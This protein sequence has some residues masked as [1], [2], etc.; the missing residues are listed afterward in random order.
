[1]AG[2]PL[3]V[4]RAL[5]HHYRIDETHS[6]AYTAWKRMGSPQKPTPEQYAALEAAGQ[7]ELLDSPQWVP[8]A[9][10]VTALDFVLPRHAVSLVR[11]GW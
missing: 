2:L 11:L 1:V 4:T 7:L 10:G 3:D 6:N 5:V 8:V 9:A